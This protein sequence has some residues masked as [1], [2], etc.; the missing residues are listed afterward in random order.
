M[1]VK[2]ETRKKLKAK[3]NSISNKSKLDFCIAQKLFSLDEYKNADK[4]LVFVSLFDEI[5]TESIINSA[6]SSGK[7]VAVPYC[8]NKFGEMEFY[9]I[10]SLDELKT[11]TF[12]V[13][14]PDIEINKKLED[15]EKSIIIVPGLS[16]DRDGNRIGYGGGYYDRF[17]ANYSG[18]SIGLC[19]GEMMFDS[20][21]TDKY[22][23]PVDIVVTDSEVFTRGGNN[24][25]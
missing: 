2:A 19:Y 5:D 21:P 7:T 25:L 3:R 22:D 17:L 14:E 8:K 23:I 24:G 9:L 1:S 16:F 18:V 20:I 10:N 13:R 4:I 11:G 15:F 12:G 6:L